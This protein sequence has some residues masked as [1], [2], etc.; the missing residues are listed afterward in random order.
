MWGR[1]GMHVKDQ[2]N[3]GTT[4]VFYP[5]FF[6]VQNFSHLYFNLLCYAP[7]FVDQIFKEPFFCPGVITGWPVH[8]QGRVSS[9]GHEDLA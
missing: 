5:Y 4:G 6:S 3:Y 7:F 1:H 8:L 2:L 9:G